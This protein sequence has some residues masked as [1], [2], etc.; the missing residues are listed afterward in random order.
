[1]VSPL[2]R[3]AGRWSFWWTG[4]RPWPLRPLRN[5]WLEPLCTVCE[6]EITTIDRPAILCAV[7]R[8]GLFCWTNFFPDNMVGRGAS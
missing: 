5:K 2:M 6:G 8:E 1:M 4:V 7:C 3:P